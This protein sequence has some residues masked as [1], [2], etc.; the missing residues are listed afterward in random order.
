MVSI[1][2]E[3]LQECG[4]DHEGWICD[5]T[6]SYWATDED[7]GREGFWCAKCHAYRGRSGDEGGSGPEDA[8]EDKQEE[9]NWQVIRSDGIRVE[10]SFTERDAKGNAAVRN[11]VAKRQGM[12]VRYTAEQQHKGE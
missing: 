9:D 11:S 12:K 7:T 3:S 8:A 2:H 5:R 4:A 6:A 10:G 1:T